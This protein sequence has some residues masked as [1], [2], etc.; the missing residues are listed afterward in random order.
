MIKSARFEQK[1]T[2]SA[3]GVLLLPLVGGR[4]RKSDAVI[5]QRTAPEPA[6]R[7]QELSAR[8][9]SSCVHLLPPLFVNGVVFPACAAVERH[10][11]RFREEADQLLKR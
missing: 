6:G 2:I 3:D 9:A 1:G 4:R 10:S 8:S 11:G 5:V 7:V